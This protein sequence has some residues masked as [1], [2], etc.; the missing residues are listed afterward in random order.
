ML[1]AGGVWTPALT[2]WQL[3]LPRTGGGGGMHAGKT[4]TCPSM[5]LTSITPPPFL[6]VQLGIFAN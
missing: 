2:S 6:N 1:D 4:Q 5:V 3:C